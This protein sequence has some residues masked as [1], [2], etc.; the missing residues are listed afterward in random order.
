MNLAHLF[1]AG[2]LVC[3]GFSWPLNVVKAYKAGTAKG[4]SLP[5]IILII[6]GYI[7]GI[8]AKIINQQFNYVLAVYFLNLAIVTTNVFV[9]I[10]NKALDKKAGNKELKVRKLDLS[11]VEKAEEEIMLNYSNS[12]DEIINKETSA[13][14]NKNAVILMGGTMDKE[15]PV[16]KL[17][18]DFGFNFDI[19][20]K[21][22]AGLSVTEAIEYFRTKIAD[23]TPEGIML[24]LGEEDLALFQKDSAAFDN[25]YLTLVDEIK[26][27]NKNCRI[28]LLSVN[29]P[30]GRKEINLLNAHISAI[31]QTEKAVFINLENAKLWNPEAT[32]AANDFAYSMGLNVRKPLR[33]VAEI[34]YS[35]AYHNLSAYKD[36]LETVLCS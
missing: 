19:Y 13:A 1:E 18:S 34:L 15:I 32:K 7:A 16:E 26:K 11:K 6:T 35:Y 29:N 24:H 17:A 8:T 10:R 33:N 25:Y 31:A 21:S 27:V 3:F 9:Y 4:T 36:S 14:E 20:N 30:E 23:L 22:E 2:M 5:F 12:L 28:A